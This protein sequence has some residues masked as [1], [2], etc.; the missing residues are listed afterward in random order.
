M[1]INAILTPVSKLTTL[2]LETTAKEA[3]KLIED[4]GFLSLPVVDGSTFIGFLSKQYIYDIYFKENRPNYDEFL[5]RP[6]KDFI[7]NRVE[8]VKDNILVEEAADIFF[9]NK[10]RFLPVVNTLD[11][12]VGIVTQKSLFGII[13][14]IYGIKDPKISILSSDFKGT[15]AKISEIISK[16]G[17]NITNIVN[18]S[19]DVMGL[20]EISIRI[21]SDDVELVIKKLAEKGFKVREFVK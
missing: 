9:N 11:E 3:V 16:N 13:T 7:H 20:Q 14:K 6:V 8:V 10:V 5:N 17:G 1:R 18:T 15:I 19:A 12:F 2:S 4:N 21:K